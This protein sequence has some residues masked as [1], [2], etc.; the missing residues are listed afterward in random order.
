MVPQGV[1][2]CDKGIDDG[3]ELPASRIARI[4]QQLQ[5]HMNHTAAIQVFSSRNLEQVAPSGVAA[6]AFLDEGHL[7]TRI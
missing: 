7:H 2:R 5:A 3:H 1:E 4:C 6:H